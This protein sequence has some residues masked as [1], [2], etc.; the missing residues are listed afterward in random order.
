MKEPNH[1]FDI[2][3]VYCYSFI[4]I[5]V[6]KAQT[7]LGFNICCICKVTFNFRAS[8][9]HPVLTAHIQIEFLSTAFPNTEPWVLA[10]VCSN[11]SSTC[12]KSFCLVYIHFHS[13]V[14]Q[15]VIPLRVII[16]YFFP[17]ISQ[18]DQ[19]ICIKDFFYNAFSDVLLS[20][21]SLSLQKEEE[22]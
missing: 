8:F 14:L 2:I 19:A 10:G 4:Y 17:I 6:Y 20:L 15:Y 7:S 11:D 21:H 1:N 5:F 13:L 16:L 22:R 3:T 9:V 18:Q 12:V